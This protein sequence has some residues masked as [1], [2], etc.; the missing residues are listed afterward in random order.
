IELDEILDQARTS[1][2][3]LE[4]LQAASDR[5]RKRL[6]NMGEVNPTAIEA[7]TEMKKRYEFIL[8]QKNDLVTA[9]ESLL[10]TIL[11]V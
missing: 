9:K 2:T 5:M 6:E 10:Q 8:E 4:E 3:S 7:F 1:D 11:E